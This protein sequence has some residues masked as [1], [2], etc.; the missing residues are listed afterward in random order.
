MLD[1]SISSQGGNSNFKVASNL[2]DTTWN[3]DWLI[4][5]GNQE[6]LSV[7]EVKEDSRTL[8]ARAIIL[9]G[10]M[11]DFNP[12]VNIKFISKC[13]CVCMYISVLLT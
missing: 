8:I 3:E 5:L 9:K 6:E 10:R 12:L 7:E 13:V 1:W 4:R 2:C 11:K